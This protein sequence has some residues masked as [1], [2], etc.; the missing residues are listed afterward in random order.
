MVITTIN[1]YV[2]DVYFNLYHM[3][4]YCGEKDLHDTRYHGCIVYNTI[5]DTYIVQIISI[6]WCTMCWYTNAPF[7]WADYFNESMSELL[8]S[9]D[10]M[11]LFFDKLLAL[12][13]FHV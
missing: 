2:S 4:Q 7:L 5:Y 3:H 12:E 13:G 9:V 10:V 1:N 6:E 8:L 11:S